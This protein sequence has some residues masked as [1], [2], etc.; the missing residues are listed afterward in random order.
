MKI[1]FDDG[2]FV[3]IKEGSPGNVA[4][5]LVAKDKDNALKKQVNSCEVSIQQF[6]NM[7]HSLPVELLPFKE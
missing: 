7:V 3:E 6:S 1:E 2:T 5:I 4:I